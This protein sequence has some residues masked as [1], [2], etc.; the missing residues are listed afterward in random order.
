MS[1]KARALA[2]AS[3]CATGRCERREPSRSRPINSAESQWLALGWTARFSAA[4]PPKSR[5]EW[6]ASRS[7]WGAKACAPDLRTSGAFLFNKRESLKFKGFSRNSSIRH[8]L[9]VRVALS[10]LNDFGHIL[11]NF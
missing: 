5:R 4:C 7:P 2:G 10:P 9:S 6:F 3:P 11:R 1:G 8:L